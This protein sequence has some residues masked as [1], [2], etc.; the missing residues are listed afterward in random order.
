MPTI[1]KLPTTLPAFPSGGGSG[2]S[3]PPTCPPYQYP[4]VSSSTGKVSCGN[5][6]TIA[7]SQRR[8]SNN[9]QFSLL[10]WAIGQSRAIA[11]GDPSCAKIPVGDE[12]AMAQYEA[13]CGTNTINQGGHTT[14]RGPLGGGTGTGGSGGG[15]G[16]THPGGPI[17][18]PPVG[19]GNGSSSGSGNGSSGGS[20]GSTGGSSGGST[21]SPSDPL[22]ALFGQ[23]FGPQ[24]T[25][26][27]ARASEGQGA[28]L[29]SSTAP[30]GGGGGGGGTS[31][32]LII[33]ILGGAGLAYYAYKKGYF[34]G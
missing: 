11:T 20:S 34:G 9:G 4:V 7:A 22:Y 33:L 29:V 12:A 30:V 6:N 21:A 10:T 15:T 3:K 2:G 5:L 25:T 32:L 31:P 8:G 26:S 23:L 16:H 17:K 13:R 14:Y 18:Y 28:F 24:T 19:G 27:P 1:Y